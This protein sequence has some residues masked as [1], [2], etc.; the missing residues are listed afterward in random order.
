MNRALTA[1]HQHG[2]S[3]LL[4][5]CLGVALAMSLVVGAFGSAGA[6]AQSSP[7]RGIYEFAGGNSSVD[8][9]NPNLAGVVLVYYWSQIE[10]QKGVFDWSQI[11]SDMAPWIAAH[12]KI[13]LRISTAG[14][15][16]WNPPYSGDGTPAWV[17]ADGARSITDNGETIPVYWDPAY[18]T[19]YESFV[20]ALGAEFDGNP[21]LAFIE[22]GVGMGGETLPETGATPAGIAAWEADGYTDSLWLSTVETIS[23][24]FEASFQTTRSYWMVDRTFFD[25]NGTYFNAVMAWFKTVSHWHLENNGLTPTQ[26]LSAQWSGEPLALEQAT[27]AQSA[28][29]CLCADISNGLDNLDATFLLIYKTDIKNPANATYLAAAESTATP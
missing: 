21:N 13:I 8:A 15:A 25:G 19:D 16:S 10:P 1:A 7:F 2:W 17:Y 9:T 22:P 20:E 28:G 11:Q 4:R 23:S 24:F 18:L 27:S 14:A 12:K 5:L 26:T 29:V 6:G 3:V